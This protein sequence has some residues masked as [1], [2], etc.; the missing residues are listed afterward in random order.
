M[1]VALPILVAVIQFSALL[2]LLLVVLAERQTM[3]V[4]LVAQ[5]VGVVPQHLEALVIRHRQVQYRVMVVVL[6][7]IAVLDITLG[8]AAVVQV[9]Q[10]LILM[11]KFLGHM[12]VMA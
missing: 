7:R 8:V 6:V 1:L 5:V 9:R 3:L 12:V 10:V 2:L 11:H 4:L